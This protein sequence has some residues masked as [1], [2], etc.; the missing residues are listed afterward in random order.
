MAKWCPIIKENV[1]Y[2]ECLECED[3]PC[4]EFE[5]KTPEQ[6]HPGLKFNDSSTKTAKRL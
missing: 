3:K 6:E 4:R 1:L 5:R 2:L